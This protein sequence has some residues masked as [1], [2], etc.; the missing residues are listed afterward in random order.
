MV[1]G[2]QSA[3]QSNGDGRPDDEAQARTYDTI[4]EVVLDILDNEGYEAARL[5][6]VARLA[7]VSLA[8]IYKFF[9]TRDDLIVAAVERWM[10]ENCYS[11]ITAPPP[12]LSL[13]EGLNWIHR[14][15]FEPWK[16]HPRML[17]AHHHARTTQ[18]GERLDLMGVGAVYRVVKD[19]LEQADPALAEDLVLILTNLTCGVIERVAVGELEVADLL[20]VLERTVYRLTSDNA[21]LVDRYAKGVRRPQEADAR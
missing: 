5:R 2:M 18:N 10:Q 4:L 13:R 20:S 21:A 3:G 11:A 9:P 15:L 12:G 16:R 8:T 1:T 7:R 17:Q 19:Y 14:Q 6:D